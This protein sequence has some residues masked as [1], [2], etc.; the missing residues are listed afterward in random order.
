MKVES[1]KCKV[2]SRFRSKSSDSFHPN[3]NLIWIGFGFGRLLLD[4]ENVNRII[5]LF[6]K[7][8]VMCSN[9]SLIGPET[10][11]NS[12]FQNFSLIPWWE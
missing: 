1:R 7:L 10:G 2:E 3:P 8:Y 5:F 12:M 11:F 4:G 6:D 9:V